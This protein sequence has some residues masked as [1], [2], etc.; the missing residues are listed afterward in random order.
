MDKNVHGT[1]NWANIECWIHFVGKT[2]PERQNDETNCSDIY[3][4][5]VNSE[6]IE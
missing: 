5:A 6:I 3:M 1:I 2:F 4:Y